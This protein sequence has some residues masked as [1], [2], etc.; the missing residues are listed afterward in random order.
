ML[1]LSLLIKING[2]SETPEAR[3][4]ENDIEL[5]F[6]S[7][8]TCIQSGL[9]LGLSPNCLKELINL[10]NRGTIYYHMIIIDGTGQ[11]GLDIAKENTVPC[12]SQT[13]GAACHCS[14]GDSK[15]KAG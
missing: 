14:L 9:P 7:P 2:F 15:R 3:H 12:S 1:F 11:K 5:G 4:N 8:V 10:K 13:E 6:K